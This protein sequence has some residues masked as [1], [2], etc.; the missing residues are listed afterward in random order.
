MFKSA[1]SYIDKCLLKLYNAVLSSGHYPSRWSESFLVPIFKYENPKLPQN[2]RG[3]AVATCLGRIFNSILNT[4]L[5]KYLA[6]NNVIHESQIGFSK[7]SRTSDHLFV[8]KCLVDKYINSGGKQL[9]VCFVDFRKAFDTV[10]VSGIRLKLLRNNI[11][12]YFYRIL[13][14]MH[15]NNYMSVK[16]DNKLTGP[17]KS[18]LG[19][20]QGDVL[21]PNIFKIFLNDFGTLID[22]SEIGAKLSHNTIGCLSY[23]DDLVLISDS[24]QGLQ[25]QLDILDTYCKDWCLTVSINKT[26]KNIFNKTGRLIK[27]NFI[28]D[29]QEIE[30]ITRYKYLGIIISASG[31]FG[32]ARTILYNKVLKG[33]FKLMKDLSGLNPSIHTIVHLFDHT[34]T[35]IALYGSEIWGILNMSEKEKKIRNL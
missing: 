9:F 31:K 25:K 23:A 26:K 4:R 29:G 32:E 22:K 33:S 27:D 21:N 8:L 35:P 14:N 7:K 2:Y 17:F 1:Q 11:N 3:I 18:Q 20:K 28:L 12:G 34:I 19:V 6:E 24:K 10:F 13:G 5:D 16:L 30:C 15:G